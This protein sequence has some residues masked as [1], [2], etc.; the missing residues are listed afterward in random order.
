[1]EENVLHIAETYNVN[2]LLSVITLVLGMICVYLLVSIVNGI[3]KK[4]RLQKL[5][6]KIE[7][8]RQQ[9]GIL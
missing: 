1:M 4:E 6:Q 7:E 8:R 9:I 5:S 3:R 2:G